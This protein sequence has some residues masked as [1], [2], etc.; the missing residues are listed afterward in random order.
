MIG[1]IRYGFATMLHSQR[2]LAPVL[3]FTGVL[4]VFSSGDSGPL[5]PVYASSAAVLF[6]CSTWFTIALLG[7]EDP[8]HR[9]IVVVT[10]GRSRRVLLA[11][12]AVAVLSCLLLAAFGLL[13]PLLVAHHPV[14]GLDLLV[15]VEA[16][17]TCAS[18]GIA[19]GLLCSR[20]VVRRQGVALVAA[21]GLVIVALLVPGMV[22][23]NVLVHL[24]G[25]ASTSATLVAPISGLLGVA[26]VIL[27]AAAAATHFLAA[28]RD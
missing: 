28:R 25:E 1:L 15:G 10:A 8:A 11:S 2:Y 24:M 27:S 17:L 6:V 5:P 21:L 7:V 19:I 14:T 22:P 18:V 9:P 3:L 12:V 13:F 26:V 20:L 16:Q 23:I 4:G